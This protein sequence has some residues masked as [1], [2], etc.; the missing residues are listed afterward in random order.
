VSKAG[1]F[2]SIRIFVL[3]LTSFGKT[4]FSVYF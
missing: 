3:P 1:N 4:D 2:L